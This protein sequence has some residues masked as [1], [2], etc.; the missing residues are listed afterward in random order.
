MWWLGIFHQGNSIYAWPYLSVLVPQLINH[1]KAHCRIIAPERPV[2]PV[3]MAEGRNFLWCNQNCHW[4]SEMSN[5]GGN[6]SQ[7]HEAMKLGERWFCTDPLDSLQIS[8]I[9]HLLRVTIFLFYKQGSRWWL[10]Q[11]QNLLAHWMWNHLGKFE[12]GDKHKM[13]F[14]YF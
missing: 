3:V 7:N 1:I 9:Q 6:Y 8:A 14:W 2:V 12:M 13:L 5:I 10:N 4:S 11:I